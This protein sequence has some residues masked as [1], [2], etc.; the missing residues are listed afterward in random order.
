M[1]KTIFFNI[2]AHGHINPSLPVITE[3]VKRGEQVICVNADNMRS[4]TESTGA[5]FVAYPEIAELEGLMAQAGG[6]NIPRNALTLTQIGERLFPFTRDL[7]QAEK[8]DYVIFDSLCAWAKYAAQSLGIPA[9][10]SIATLLI[11]PGELPPFTLG[12]VAQT[13]GQMLPVMPEYLRT[14]R[15]MRQTFGVQPGGLMSA[16]MSTGDL[17][18]IYT[19]AQ[20]QPSADR[21]GDR[22][23]FVGPSLS[24]RQ[25]HN[26]FPF[27][28]LVRRPL[29]YISLGTINNNKPDFYRQCF[30]AF[31]DFPG[32]VIL[33]V[34]KKIDLETLD[35]IP[36]NFIVRGFVPQ[37]EVLQRVD[38][39]ITHGGMNSVQEGL[40]YGV[41][42]I[43]IPQQVEQ[44]VVARQVQKQGAGLALG[45]KPPFGEVNTAELRA[46]A[47]HILSDSN[48]YRRAACRLGES[49]RQ[50]GGYTRAVDEIMAFT[51]QRQPS[52]V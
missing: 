31:A 35:E 2:P 46:A 36:D 17:N 43:A 25:N 19:S 7:L 30:S 41:P 37:L 5:A 10:A 12:M 34:G 1:A 33:S 40:W 9:V 47:D 20:F 23:K 13:L 48:P 8:P 50:A 51:R 42:L 29:I 27:D 26:D 6:G 22:Y 4:Q 16:V 32:Q 15:R 39:F 21:F 3:L 45:V 28:Q 38:L 44:A 49:F 24:P 18:L 11:A 14:A 52:S